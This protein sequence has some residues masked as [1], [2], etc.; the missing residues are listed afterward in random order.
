MNI[1]FPFGTSSLMPHPSNPLCT[2]SDSKVGQTR[3]SRP[4]TNM[5][6][7]LWD[8]IYFCLEM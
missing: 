7:T 3:G 4:M 1:L 5:H 8:A 6:F 2:A